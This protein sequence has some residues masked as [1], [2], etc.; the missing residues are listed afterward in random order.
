MQTPDFKWW[1]TNAARVIVA[2]TILGILWKAWSKLTDFFFLLCGKFLLAIIRRNMREYHSVSQEVLKI[3]LSHIAT[4][5]KMIER[6]LGTMDQ[7]VTMVEDA[8]EDICKIADE[9]KE[10]GKSISRQ[11]GELRRVD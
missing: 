1:D 11:E 10:Q 4:G 2:A 5:Q 3:E 6:L 8:K 7:I 9:Q